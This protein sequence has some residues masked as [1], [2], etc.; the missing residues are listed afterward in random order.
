MIDIIGSPSGNAKAVYFAFQNL[1]VNCRI[2]TNASEIY[3]SEKL[4]L[5]GVGAFGAL[6]HYL[7]EQKLVA[8]IKTKVQEG[9]KL[10]GICLGM[11]ILFDKSEE[12][13]QHPGL[14]LFNLSCQKFRGERLRVPHS[15]WNEVMTSVSHDIFTGLASEF[16]AFFSHSYYVPYDPTR[17]FAT[18]EYECKFSSVFAKENVVGVQFHPERSQKT[19]ARLLS[20]FAD[21]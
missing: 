10:L 4:V 20:N 8:P 19:G 15:G 1:G 7:S 13:N 3:N 14:G 17:T 5:P 6:A 16:A 11:Q 21:W 2:V 12:S 18:T 9:T